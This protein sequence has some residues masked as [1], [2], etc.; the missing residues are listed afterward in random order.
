[1]A[2]IIDDNPSVWKNY[3]PNLILAQPY[4][5]WNDDKDVL[6][7]KLN[8]IKPNDC[9][10]WFLTSFLIRANKI[11]FELRNKSVDSDVRAI[12]VKLNSSTF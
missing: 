4:Y 10:L 9:F 7:N 11:F 5:Y 1:M 12:I 2:L 3:L 6:C 8:V